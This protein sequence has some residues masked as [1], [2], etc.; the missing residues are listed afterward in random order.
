VEEIMTNVRKHAILFA[1]LLAASAAAQAPLA[2]GPTAK[3]KDEKG[4][5]EG[6]VVNASSGDPLKKVS[7]TLRGGS[8]SAA[9]KTESD[10]EGRFAFRDLDP[11]RYTLMGDKAGFARQAFGA[12]SNPA[13]GSALFLSAGRKSKDLVFKMA[14][15]AIISGHV[16]DEEGEPVANAAVMAMTTL[17]QHGE[18][19]LSPL[20]S[21]ATNDL[22]EYRIAGLTAGSYVVAATS[23]MLTSGLTGA[24][25]K[26]A[27]D[28][29]ERDYVTTYYPN[30][31]DVAV[32]VRLQVAAGGEAGGANIHLAKADTVR[33][34]GKV[35]GGLEGKQVLLMLV[36]KSDS[37]S[38][39]RV[40]AGRS[41][42]AQSNGSFDIAG[43]S[44]GAYILATISEDA[45]S[46]IRFASQEIQVG[47]QH[48]D[49]VAMAFGASGEIAGA[50]AVEARETV[51][52]KAM[53]VTLAAAPGAPTFTTPTG[54]A[55][56]GGKFVLKNVPTARYQAQVTGAPENSYVKSVEFGGRE[57][58]DDGFVF[59][60]AAGG[61][62]IALSLAGAQ[63]EGTVLNADKEPAA[64]ATV[65]L[66]P[67][68]GRASL[69]REVKTGQNGSFAIKG[70]PPGEY[71][72][73]AWEDVE[74]AAYKDP[75]YLKKLAGSAEQLSLQENDHKAVSLKAI[76]PAQ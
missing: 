2:E 70:I 68:S 73:L 71:Q 36:P 69:Y 3:A 24:S 37:G 32:A 72:A 59:S 56:E 53:Q 74:T 49:G 15:G 35:S 48:V 50:V 13:S 63:V 16:L 67:A 21:A 55:G 23:R 9:T 41:A 64:D 47:K 1:A 4:S 31:T 51:D 28:A 54:P 57:A 42:V 19:Q 34:R 65:V 18:P 6:R 20:G 75:E 76:A 45:N 10:E 17:Y 38:A 62:T 22:G 14:P 11:G 61:L 39:L 43:V 27:G 7:L 30:S 33:I 26:A 40:T 46:G 60:G 12:R 29:P 66:I 5:L 52:F 44:P 8:A 25:N 58:P